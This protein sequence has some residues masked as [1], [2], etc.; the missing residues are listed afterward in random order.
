MGLYMLIED[1]DEH[2]I[3]VSTRDGYNRFNKGVAR[4]NNA[5]QQ[6]KLWEI[7]EPS[8]YL[9]RAFPYISTGRI[10]EGYLV[11]TILGSACSYRQQPAKG[12]FTLTFLY[13]GTS[14]RLF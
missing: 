4:I 1:K 6:V 13:V 9:A 10:V 12:N 5:F 3:T 7:A 2:L 14:A 11:K 8:L